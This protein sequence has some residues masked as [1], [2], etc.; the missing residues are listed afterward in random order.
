M[1]SDKLHII[2]AKTAPNQIKF[3][4]VFSDKLHIFIAKTAPNQIKC[5]TLFSDK[6][7]IIVAKHTPNQIKC[8]TVFSDKLH[9]IV[10]KTAP[11]QIKPSSAKHVMWK[12]FSCFRFMSSTLLHVAFYTQ[13]ISNTIDQFLFNRPVDH[14][15]RT[16]RLS[17][18]F[19]L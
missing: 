7:H 19:L 9:I 1:F 15:S 4:T 11:N 6:L 5:I 3:I 13:H 12:M 10:A 18:L 14:W 8:I 17:N 16:N 2:R